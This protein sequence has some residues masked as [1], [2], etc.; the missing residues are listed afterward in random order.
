MKTLVS[1]VSV[2]LGSWSAAFLLAL[3][4]AAA[5]D[6]TA[7]ELLPPT[8]IGF[9]E[10]PEPRTL[11]QV[12][13]ECPLAREIEQQPAYQKALAARNYQQL[14]TALKLVE[15][16]L[17]MTWRR[18]LESL[19]SGGL[20]VGFD[21]PTQGVVVL[22]Q[23]ED[24]PLALKGRDAVLALA[25]A[26]AAAKGKPDPVKQDEL[27]G[28]TIHEIGDLRLAVLGKWLLA[29]NKQLLVSMVL[30]NYLGSGLSLGADA[31]FSTVRNSRPTDSAAWLYVDLRLLRLSGVLRNVASKKSSNPP[32]E[33][34][35][36]GVLGVLPDAPYATASLRL[37]SSRIRLTAALPGDPR[38]AAKH[39]EFYFG[40]EGNGTAPAL[41]RPQ[42]TLL[43]LSAYRDFASLWRHAP[44]LFDE[45][46]NAKFA[47][48]ESGLATFFGGRNFRD[49]IL[50]NLQPG[51]QFVVA[52]QDFSQGDVTPAIKLPAA[53]LVVQMKQP[54]K[55]ARTFKITF[56][57]VIGFL[58]IIGGMKGLPPLDL[59]SERVG[60]AVVIS[61]EY[62]PPDKIET[63]S[64]APIHHNAS[65]TAVFWKDVFILSSARPL[66]LELIELAQRQLPEAKGINASLLVEGPVVHTVLADNRSSLI[67]RNMLDRGHDRAAAESEIDGMLKVL[68]NFER[69]SVQLA[70]DGKQLELSIDVEL[71]GGK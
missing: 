39:R 32:A 46:V 70:S 48:A 6:K 43:T 26:D 68:S 40:P 44:D 56:Q 54:E 65:P 37:D 3:S 62:L 24:E 31:Q 15:D 67:A 63:R 19:A 2:L 59:N 66:A 38:A 20:F 23:A 61:T 71:A 53:A 18:G 41:L 64:E 11:M 51:V 29:T 21:L 34:L 57:S 22:M 47:E 49:E 4:T 50:G 27:R 55:T 42:R 10:V 12:I 69:S 28:V 45:R 7:L 36:G 8:T 33:L 17:G 25:R 58:N 5:A 1:R 35:V 30:E 16:K 52:R 13:F 9:L 60:E 14:V